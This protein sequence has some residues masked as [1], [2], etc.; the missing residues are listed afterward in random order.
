MLRRKL[1]AKT[2]TYMPFLRPLLLKGLTLLLCCSMVLTPAMVSADGIL[3]FGNFDLT[4]EIELGRKFNI[5]V[6]SQLPLIEDPEIVNY[7]RG[8][9]NNITKT[10]PPQ[11]FEIKTSVVANPAINAFAAPAGYVFVFSG[12]I[13]NFENE[14]E[15]AGV[16]AHELAHVSQRHIAHRIEQMQVVSLLSMLGVLA[17]AFLGGEHAQAIM[18]GSAAA[19]QAAMLNYSRENEREADQV[20][21]NF[22][23]AAGY[24]PS[25][26]PDAFAHI[27]RNQW[28][29]GGGSIPTYLSTHPGIKERIGYL[30]Q[31]VKRL[32]ADVRNRTI[33]N[34]RFLRVRMLLRAR[35]TDAKI[36]LQYFTSNKDG[37]PFLREL[38]LGIV[39]D[40]LNR[41]SDAAESFKKAEHINP[42]D[43]LLLREKGIFYFQHGDF[44]AAGQYLQ[45]ALFEA[46][47]DLMALFYYARMQA[48]MGNPS[49]A[50][51]YFDRIQKQVPEDAE[52]HYYQGRAL[53]EDRQFFKAH[54]HLAYSALYSQNLKQLR[55]H[56]DKAKGLASSTEQNKEFE[57]LEKKVE[58]RREFW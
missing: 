25:G 6:R 12:L 23:V 36:A 47:K 42:D 31:R 17:G 16:I 38:G 51:E 21:M 22:L 18:T 4:D 10:M 14:A 50:V 30:E 13:L 9:V 49:Q 34:S 29:G 41:V 45:R 33:D 52:V 55:F 19:G 2:Y 43:P 24:P 54:L 32:P 37:D 40:R 5:M 58:E 3:N 20:G 7:V 28:L 44:D 35:Y 11:F 15:V 39:Y 26:L 8:L 1:S 56:M 46:P 57:E 53:G 48:E 27:L